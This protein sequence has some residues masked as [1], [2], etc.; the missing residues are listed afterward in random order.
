MLKEKIIGVEMRSDLKDVI[1]NAVKNLE[2]LQN[3]I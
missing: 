1:K 2:T 3:G